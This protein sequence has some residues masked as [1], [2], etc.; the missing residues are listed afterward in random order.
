VGAR[1]QGGTIPDK[2]RNLVGK[3]VERLDRRK[4]R[5]AASKYKTKDFA[6]KKPF[7]S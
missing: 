7:Q 6:L 3:T 4:K 2:Q 5:S 1:K